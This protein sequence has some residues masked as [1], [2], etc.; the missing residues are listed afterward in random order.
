MAKCGYAAQHAF[1]SFH[2]HNGQPIHNP[3]HVY[4]IHT[5]THTHTKKHNINYMVMGGMGV[6]GLGVVRLGVQAPVSVD[7]ELAPETA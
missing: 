3:Q 4:Y 7:G 1:L 5:S 2:F 6:N